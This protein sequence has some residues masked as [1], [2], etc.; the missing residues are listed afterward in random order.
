MHYRKVSG[1]TRT[2]LT[3]LENILSSHS[4]VAVTAHKL[5]F[6]ITNQMQNQFVFKSRTP[7]SLVTDPSVSGYR[8][9]SHSEINFVGANV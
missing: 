5:S 6:Q 8:T 1:V 4:S 7:N 3:F 2:Y 9:Y